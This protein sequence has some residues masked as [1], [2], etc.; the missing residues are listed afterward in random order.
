MGMG[1]FGLEIEAFSSFG[2]SITTCFVMMM[3]EFD[4]EPL[5][6]T[7]RT[8]AVLWFISFQ[9]LTVLIMMNMLLAI[10]MDTYEE[11][12]DTVSNKETLLEHVKKTIR[13]HRSIRK[14]DR[15]GLKQIKHGLHQAF[16][17][18][19]K[20]TLDRFSAKT[21]RDSP[22]WLEVEVVTVQAFVDVVS[23]LGEN[24]AKR[25]MVGAVCSWRQARAEPVTLSETLHKVSQV[26]CELDQ[27]I[28]QVHSTPSAT[29]PN[30]HLSRNVS[31]NLML[32]PPG[33]SSDDDLSKKSSSCT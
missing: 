17:D 15:I 2:R 30:D 25:L 23:G 27:F 19:K 22:M 7:G 8:V 11:V 5:W 26:H 32:V 28:R 13:R 16:P 20:A 21:T 4:V 12:K 33:Q 3:G 9:C 10:I 18:S 24:Q 31:P 29:T 14:G 1:L 6:D